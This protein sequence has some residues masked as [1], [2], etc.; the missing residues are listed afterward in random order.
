MANNVDLVLRST[1]QGMI[2]SGISNILAQLLAC[3]QAGVSPTVSDRSSLTADQ[4]RLHR[5]APPR[6]PLHRLL[7]TLHPAQHRMA[8]PAG[9]VLS[10]P[11]RPRQG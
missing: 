6:L 5:F 1:I 4:D 2:L 11:S 8:V 3:Y 10:R 9:D 7:P